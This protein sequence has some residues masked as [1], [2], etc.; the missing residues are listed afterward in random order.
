[1]IDADRTLARITEQVALGPRVV[2]SPGHARVHEL[3]RTWLAGADEVR[4]HA[5]VEAFFGRAVECR[6]LVGRFHGDRAGRWLLGTHYDTRPWADRDPDPARRRAPV[7]GANDGGSGTAVLAELALELADR[8]DRPTVDLVLF[9]AE[10]WHE[11]DGKEVSLGSRRFVGDLTADQSPDRVVI[12]DMVGGSGL[13]LDLDVNSQ[14]HGPS[15]AWTLEC[16]RL[17]QRLG[18]PAF[19]LHKAQPA[20]WVVCDHS[21]FQ[22]AGIPTALLI[23]LDYPP[24]HTVSDLPEHCSADALAQIGAWLEALLF[25]ADA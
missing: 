2:G 24:W 6:N 15:F 3:L 14:L 5:F 9:D 20:K 12:L 11:I 25:T 13:K 17:G 7:P 8:R 21:P 10:D 16:F 19:D 4:E 22:A 18:L 23:D 1:M